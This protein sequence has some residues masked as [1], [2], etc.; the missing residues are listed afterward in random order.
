MAHIITERA[1][2]I[3]ADAIYSV[4][5]KAQKMLWPQHWPLMITHLLQL[6]PCAVAT[7]HQ[8][9]SPK[10]AGTPRGQ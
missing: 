8:H 2:P 5:D 10:Q 4:R 9:A 7:G 3:T 6:K 1:H